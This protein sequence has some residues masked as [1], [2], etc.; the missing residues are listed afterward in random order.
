MS[1]SDRFGDPFRISLVSVSDQFLESVADHFE[2]PFRISFGIRCGSVFESVSD[3]KRN[4]EYN[5][6]VAH[7]WTQNGTVIEAK[8]GSA[9][10]PKWNTERFRLYRIVEELYPE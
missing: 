5:G 2:D 6:N 10:E 3:P 4:H 9:M 8:T 1:V 7:N